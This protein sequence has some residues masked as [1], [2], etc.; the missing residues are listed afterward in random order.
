LN[1]VLEALPF[2][3][4]DTGLGSLGKNLLDYHEQNLIADKQL[5]LFFRYMKLLKRSQSDSKI[6]AYDSLINLVATADSVESSEVSIDLVSEI[7]R[8]A[9]T[10]AE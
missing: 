2:D 7:R 10:A 1:K 5:K 8:L 4:I 3:C 6:S 9:Q